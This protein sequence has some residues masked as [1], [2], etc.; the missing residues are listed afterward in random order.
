[1]S[2]Y[3]ISTPYK[4][5]NIILTTG[6]SGGGGTG[7][8]SASTSAVWNGASISQP[9]YST[10]STAAGQVIIAGDCEFKGN[11]TWKGRD[12]KDWLESIETRLGMLQ[13]NPALEA[14][15]DELADI[16]RQY[17][18]LEKK[19]LEKQRVFDI[20]KKPLD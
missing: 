18:E 3:K 8:F 1:M 2:S 19:L 4:Y 10:A 6:G 7:S 5:G 13:P 14:E 20:L 12:L 16:R 9:T 15:W 11:I 17:V